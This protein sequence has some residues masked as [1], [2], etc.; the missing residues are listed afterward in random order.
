MKKIFKVAGIAILLLLVL[1]A[2]AATYIST[3]LPDVGP[4]ETLTVERTPERIE[5]G[6]Y[7]ASSVSVCIDCHSTRD[8]SKF[9]GPIVPGT[10]GKGGER[11]DQSVGLPG[12][13]FSKNITP[14]GLN[15]YSDGELLRVIT[16]G[17]NKEGKAM[18]PLMPYP[19]Y[20]KM[21]RED[22]FSIIAYLR[23]LEPIQN[24]IPSSKP[25]FPI[26]ILINTMP[27]KADYQTRPDSKDQLAYGAY[28]TNIAGCVECH[29]RFE[30]GKII[31]EF[32]FGGSR[33]FILP[34]GS[35]V[36]SANI[37]PDDNT[38][39]GKWT[40]EQ[41][42]ARFT[43]YADSSFTLPEVK[44]GEFNTI[45]PWS[46]YGKMKEEDLEAIF[47]YLKTVK[48]INN[49]VALFTAADKVKSSK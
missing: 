45:M 49:K 30:K 38:G 18:F 32:S 5:R 16:T 33:D 7:L 9:S 26:N 48:P 22:L 4:A 31:P 28:M 36:R 44:P 24:D 46:M 20:G 6:R 29:T 17:V 10:I 43:M 40:K 23:T 34:D 14:E 21:D 12:A 37:S 3:A 27:Q 8:W 25:D 35:I 41:F 39:I 15:R 1:V 2:A 19:Y 11:F 47:A 42:V 13:F